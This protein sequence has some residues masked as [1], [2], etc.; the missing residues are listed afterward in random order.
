[1]YRVEVTS[2]SGDYAN[3][4]VVQTTNPGTLHVTGLE[5]G[6]SY[7][8]RLQKLKDNYAP[9]AWT[10][11]RRITPDG[12]QPLPKT[13]IRVAVQQGN[14]ALVIYEPVKKATG[15]VFEY[16]KSSKKPEPWQETLVNSARTEHLI[17]SGLDP[18]V[19]YEFRV[20]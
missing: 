4:K 9:S 1:L 7:F 13:K 17:I 20:K 6:K 19:K 2:K 12:G 10:S 15:Y 5:N 14:E 16:R 3:A 11:E 8:Y 18:K